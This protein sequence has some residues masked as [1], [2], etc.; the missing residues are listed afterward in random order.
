[1]HKINQIAINNANKLLSRKCMNYLKPMNEEIYLRIHIK[2][3]KEHSQESVEQERDINSLTSTIEKLIENPS[4]ERENYEIHDEEEEKEGGSKRPCNLL[5]HH[6]SFSFFDFL[7]S[8]LQWCSSL[9]QPLPSSRTFLSLLLSFPNW[10][11]FTRS[12]TSITRTHKINLFTNTYSYICIF[13][14]IPLSFQQIFK[15]TPY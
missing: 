9:T 7:P 15:C 11:S 3:E 4:C 1:M 12:H 2:R 5:R 6:H 14:P 13:A 10:V 8:F